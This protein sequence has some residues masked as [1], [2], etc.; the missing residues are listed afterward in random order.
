VYDQGLHIA[1]TLIFIS[2]IPCDDDDDDN[3][4]NNNNNNKVKVKQSK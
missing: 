3:N 2:S 1:I 4:N